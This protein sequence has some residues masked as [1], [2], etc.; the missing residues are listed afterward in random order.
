MFHFMPANKKYLLKSP[1]ARASKVIAAILGALM[2]TV[3]IHI[4]AGLL[5]DR[6]LVLLSFWFTVPILWCFLIATVYWIKSPW[7]VW[8]LLLT[9]ALTCCAII[10]FKM[11]G[12]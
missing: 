12:R 4:A 9:I 11:T 10:Y 2:A 7:K 6:D 8:V 5:W 1:W 3:V